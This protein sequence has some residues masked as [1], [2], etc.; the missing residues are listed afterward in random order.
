MTGLSRLPLFIDLGAIFTVAMLLPALQAGVL[1]DLPLAAIFLESAAGLALLLALLGLA[2]RPAGPRRAPVEVLLTILGAL[3]LLPLGLAWPLAV[4]LPDTGLFNAWWEMVSCLTLTGASLYDPRQLAEPLHLWR[5]LVGWIGGLLVLVSAV[6]LMAPLGIGGFELTAAPPARRGRG[7]LRAAGPRPAESGI[8]PAPAPRLR[9][10]IAEVAPIYAGLTGA[11]WLGLVAAGDA[12]FVALMRA[13]G[14]ISTS[15]I[16]PVAGPV[17]ETSGIAAELVLVPFLLPALSRRMW[18]GGDALR[19][20]RLWHEDP[21]LRLAAG[22]VLM[23]VLIVVVR[24]AIQDNEI[25]EGAA[26]RSLAGFL[27]AAWGGCF[28][29]LSFL[30]TTGWTSVSWDRARDWSG[31]GAPGLLL[32]GLAIM[33]G[34]VATAAGGVKLLRIHALAQHTRRELQ[35]IVHPASVAG[36]GGVTRRLRGEGAR[37]AFVVF[38][39]FA[40][41]VAAVILALSLGRVAFETA[42]LLA[43]SALTNTGPLAHTIPLATTLEGTAGAAGAPWQGWAGLSVWGK[44][45]LAAAMAVGRL[46][47]LAI[48]ALISPTFWRR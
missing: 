24:Q 37:L 22:V 4:A 19:A 27:H 36:G 46:E 33:G 2:V 17:G 45:V 26:A 1:G 13:M 28:G 30:T 32:A 40:V 18:P 9:R 48:I 15:G 42:T 16:A 21:E 20:T 3:T 39:L 34:G 11:L 41:S 23:V 38:M 5:G 7:P 12:S 43:V 44:A 8:G 10:A 29:A 14:T 25:V 35:R 6:S 31:L 47:T